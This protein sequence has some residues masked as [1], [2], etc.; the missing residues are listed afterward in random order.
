MANILFIGLG[1]MG[2]PMAGHLS[3]AG[4]NVTVYNRSPA[5]ADAWVKE[6][7]GHKTAALE[8][9]DAAFDVVCLCVGRDDDVR[10]I[11]TGQHQLLRQ[12]TKQTLVIDH[13]TTSATLA[14]EMAEACAA[15]GI[16]FADAPVSGGQQGAINGQL[17]LM[18]GA[19]I[20]DFAS[21]KALTAPYTRAIEHMGPVGS[22]QKTKM[23]NQI[24]VAGLIQAL[25]EG[26]FFAQKAGLDVQQVMR[27]ISQGAA[28]SWQMQNRYQSMLDN[29]Y[30]HGFAVNW[31]HKDLQICLAEAQQM[32][33]MLPVTHLVDDYYAEL[34]SMGAGALDTS[35][36]L[37][38]LQKQDEKQAG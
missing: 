15:L 27:V 8:F 14:T 31:M 33:V 17:S 9:A 11:L 37:L 28:G 32:G 22:G 34:Q 30:Q 24:C 3:R 12:L 21:V 5:R 25:A 2:Y 4:N 23:V 19:T 1:N 10:N 16:R 38:R 20:S 18:V 13:T 7:S 36:L 35:S 29:H 6:F 26:M